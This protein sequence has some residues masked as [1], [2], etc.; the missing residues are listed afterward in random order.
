[1]KIVLF[2]LLYLS[3]GFGVSLGWFIVDV[4]THKQFYRNA[5]IDGVEAS[6][7]VGAAIVWPIVVLGLLFW[8]IGKL[9]VKMLAKIEKDVNGD[10]ED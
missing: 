3:I 2:I 7:F 4:R 10:E 1:M 8:A 6:I 9:L 5:P